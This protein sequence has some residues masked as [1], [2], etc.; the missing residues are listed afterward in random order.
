MRVLIGIP[1]RQAW[2]P[3]I[4]LLAL[5]GSPMA[6]VGNLSSRPA[7]HRSPPRRTEIKPEPN[8]KTMDFWVDAGVSDAVLQGL[9]WLARHQNPDG[10]WSVTGF[11]NRCEGDKRCTPNPGSDELDLAITGLAL[12][13]FLVAGYTHLSRD[14]YRGICFGDTIKRG[15]QILMRRQTQA[16]DFG[17]HAGRSRRALAHALAAF[18]LCESYSLTASAILKDSAQS[19]VSH[20]LKLRTSGEAWGDTI[21]TAWSLA[22]IHS[23]WVGELELGGGR[24]DLAIEV[25]RWLENRAGRDGRVG[26]RTRAW[27]A[28]AIP[29]RNDRF[30]PLPTCTAAAT[31]GRTW[32]DLE[33]KKSR[34][35]EEQTRLLLRHLP[36]K[37]PRA[38]DFH[39]AFWTGL[40]LFRLHGPG[41]RPWKEFSATVKEAVMGGQLR[42]RKA[43]T[44][45]SW[46]PDDKWSCEAGRVYAT[47]MNLLTLEVYYRYAGAGFGDPSAP[48]GL[49]H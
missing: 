17:E 32:I 6:D 1:M 28:S 22:A 33:F 45:G 5:A 35:A 12:A 42:D 13:P 19:A 2:L 30:A 7:T 3:S 26:Y 43:C 41:G 38:R 34:L 25:E 20:C 44:F 47:A 39:H 9:L 14:T 40:A 49:K 10:S 18:A 31:A 27:D 16:G 4:A 11:V 21:T 48:K 23:A 37:D 24:R 15:L 36:D 46:Q 29:G 8:P